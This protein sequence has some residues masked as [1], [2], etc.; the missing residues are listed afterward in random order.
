MATFYQG[1]S[2]IEVVVR[3]EDYGAT[4]KGANE[5]DTAET[6]EENKNAANAS[7]NVANTKP[8]KVSARIMGTKVL[9]ASVAMTRLGINYYATGVGY[10]TGDAAL[11]EATQRTVEMATEGFGILSSVGI[12]ALYGMR[13]GAIGMT[14]G[15]IAALATTGVSLGVKYASKQRDYDYK[16]FKENNAIEYRRARANISLTTG[17]LR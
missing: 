13:G 4:T 5:K 11:Q 17:R 1:V 15:A 6:N 10:R 3:K 2:K 7:G 9:A 12:G 16:M 8:S 14:L